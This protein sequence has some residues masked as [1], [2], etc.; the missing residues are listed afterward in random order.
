[1]IFDYHRNRLGA[2]TLYKELEQLP[3]YDL[4]II[5][6]YM[7]SNPKNLTLCE[8]ARFHYLIE[9]KYDLIRDKKSRLLSP[10]VQKYL[11]I[12]YGNKNGKY[13]NVL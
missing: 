8:R 1:M 4:F 5:W 9:E 13:I 6:D 7:T 11:L 3:K 12:K 10:F 2:Y